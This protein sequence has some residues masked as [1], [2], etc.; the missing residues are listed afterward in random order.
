MRGGVTEREERSLFVNNMLAIQGLSKRFQRGTRLERVALD[1]IN[2]TIAAGTLAVVIGG[3]G[4]GKSTLLASIAG[5][6][7]IDAGSVFIDGY[8]VTTWP[9]HRRATLTARVFQD[10]ALGTAGSMTIEENLALAQLRGCRRSLV[11]QLM[12]GAREERR[13]WLQSAGLGL[14]KRLDT[15]VELLSG[16]QR[17]ALSLLMALVGRPRLLLLDEHTAALDPIAAKTVMETTLRLVRER[18][19]TTLMVTHD[20]RLALAFADQLVMLR[21]GRKVLDLSGQDVHS[22][23]FDELIEQYRVNDER[24]LLG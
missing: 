16:G 10:P 15:R 11:A 24:I 23:S 20:V 9:V 2:L 13:S 3:N 12:P 5:K 4:A 8:D 7:A 6:L 14:E 18:Q 17:Q 1:G 21:E 19:V 22:M